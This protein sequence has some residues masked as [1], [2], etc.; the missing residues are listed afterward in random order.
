MKLNVNKAQ[1]IQGYT[2]YGYCILY[3]KIQVHNF[4]L[5]EVEQCVYLREGFMTP[6]YQDKYVKG[7][8]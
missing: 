6:Y 8:K 2:Y 4:A 5:Y 7:E 3:Q 1:K